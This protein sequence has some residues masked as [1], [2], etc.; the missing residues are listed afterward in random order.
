LTGAARRWRKEMMKQLVLAVLL[1]SSL[2]FATASASAADVYAGAPRSSV[3]PQV[4]VQQQDMTFTS[5]GATLSGTLYYPEAG[6]DVAA[7]VVLHGASEPSRDD[8]LYSHLK[9]MLPPLGVAVFAFD[10]RGTGKSGGGEHGK[11]DFGV[12]SDDGVAALR[13]LMKDPRIDPKRVGF[14]GLSQGGGLALLAVQKEPRAAFAI[15][16]SPLISTGDV[17]MMFASRNIMRIKGYPQSEID[18]AMATRR[19]IDDYDRGK[20]DRATVE[21]M[22]DAAEHKPWFKQIYL[23]RDKI[24]PKSDWREQISTDPMKSLDGS[25]VPTLIIFGQED[26]WIPV[27]DALHKLESTKALHPNIT[28]RVVSGATHEMM[29][30]VDRKREIDPASFSKFAPNAPAYFGV[31]GAWLAERGIARAEFR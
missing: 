15:A 1:G 8:H 4:V 28:T 17:Q 9:Q 3:A 23:G 26:V 5:D 12:L 10:R 16:V 25:R 7:V 27:A 6:R 11:Q 19:A 13:M 30:G 14:W 20:I 2:S 31:L 24:D 21:R 22:L 29:L 18:Q